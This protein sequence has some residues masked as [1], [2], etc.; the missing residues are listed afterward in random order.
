MYFLFL[1][2]KF[3]KLLEYRCE[4][5][6]VPIE[7]CDIYDGQVYKDFLK[8]LGDDI[9]ISLTLNYDG[10]P[11]FKSSGM[12]IWPVQLFINELPLLMR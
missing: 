2:S 4:R 3:V 6:Y 12:Q 10:A 8:D 5:K 7:L 1:D 11:K 9:S